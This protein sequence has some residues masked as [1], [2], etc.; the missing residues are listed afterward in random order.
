MQ[1]KLPM[2]KMDMLQ[3]ISTT[4]VFVIC[5]QED[6]QL[7]KYM[8]MDVYRFSISWPNIFLSKLN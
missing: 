8:G 2:E 1:V 6:V 7:L 3:W 4:V 5:G